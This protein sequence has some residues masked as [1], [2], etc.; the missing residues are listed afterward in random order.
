[1]AT[2]KAPNYTDAQV[3]IMVAA[4]EAN[5]GIAN[6]AVATTLAADARMNI[7]GEP[8]QVRSIIAKLR[9]VVDDN[10]DFTYEKVQPTTK[11]GKPVQKKLDLV[12]RIADLADVPV[13]KLD[14]LEKAPKLALE[15]LAASLAA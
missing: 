2:D 5:G 15:T 4:I 3:A 12:T 7:D 8:R 14:G 10:A 6:K 1:M 11:D 13:A 9:R